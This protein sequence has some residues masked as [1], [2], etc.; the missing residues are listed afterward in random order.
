MFA[1]FVGWEALEHEGL[2]KALYFPQNI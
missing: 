1:P 2:P